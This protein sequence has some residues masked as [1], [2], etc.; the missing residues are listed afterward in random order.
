M[1]VTVECT[2]R[3]ADFLARKADALHILV[4]SMATRLEVLVF[5]QAMRTPPRPP[6]RSWCSIEP[7][8]GELYL[9]AR[10]DGPLGRADLQI[11]IA[12]MCSITPCG[13]A[14]DVHTSIASGSSRRYV[15]FGFPSSSA[16][17]LWLSGLHRLLGRQ[18]DEKCLRAAWRG[19]VFSSMSVEDGTSDNG[20]A[21]RDLV[22]ISLFKKS[23][24]ER[25]GLTFMRDRARPVRGVVVADILRGGFAALMTT[26]QAGDI[27]HAINAEPVF[28][29][30]EAGLL[31]QR[32]VGKISIAVLRKKGASSDN[33]T[34][35]NGSAAQ[36]FVQSGT[37]LPQRRLSAPLASALR[38][39]RV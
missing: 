38:S 2:T 32:S 10:Q 21:G 3:E 33:I 27:I 23:A 28:T 37:T 7:L 29:V 25:I 8:D 5:D 39:L 18:M 9:L 17:Q 6:M 35:E 31:L 24:E 12:C 22:R 20:L 34:K 14:L 4:R 15:L 13:D 36:Q 16:Q 11:P 26:L 30:E 1:V 19:A